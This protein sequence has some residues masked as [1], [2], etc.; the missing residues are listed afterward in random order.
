MCIGYILFNILGSISNGV[1]AVLSRSV[2]FDSV[3]PR[4][5]AMG[6]LQA[7]MLEWAAMPSC[8]GSS[9][10][11]KILYR[12]S[13]QRSPDSL[14]AELPGKP[15]IPSAVP[16]PHSATSFRNLYHRLHAAKPHLRAGS[17]LPPGGFSVDSTVMSI[18]RTH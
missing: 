8:R 3:T 9:Q 2:M 10:P 13:Y 7:R 6:I 5:G 1:H 4:A 15:T 14:P 18:T 17:V 16:A 11:R 12:L